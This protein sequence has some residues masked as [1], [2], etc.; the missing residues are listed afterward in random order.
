MALAYGY[1]PAEKR[2]LLLVYWRLHH[3][4]PVAHTAAAFMCNVFLV[5]IG[6]FMQTAAPAAATSLAVK[7]TLFCH[8]S[9]DLISHLCFALKCFFD[10]S[11]F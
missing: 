4:P 2:T 6:L 10:V 5:E 8:Q 11:A 7:Y 3:F 1:G 9:K